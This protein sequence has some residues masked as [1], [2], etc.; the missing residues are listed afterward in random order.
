[1]TN[2]QQDTNALNQEISWSTDRETAVKLIPNSYFSTCQIQTLRTKS[3]QWGVM[4][5]HE[6]WMQSFAACSMVATHIKQWG[7]KECKEAVWLWD[8]N[9]EVD[10][11]FFIFTHLFLHVFICFGMMLFRLSMLDVSMC[12][13]NFCFSFL[14]VLLFKWLKFINEIR[15][16]FSKKVA[17]Y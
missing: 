3:A 1:M 5:G 7:N 14:V 12:V 15:K 2:L 16:F 11:V 17:V 10:W 6:I 8:N 13:C 4:L 9:E